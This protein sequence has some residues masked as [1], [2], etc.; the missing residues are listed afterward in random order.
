MPSFVPD[1]SLK[2]TFT[3]IV[4]DKSEYENED[5]SGSAFVD[6][7]AKKCV[8]KSCKFKFCT[9][10]RSYFRGALFEDCDFQG[11]R[12][13]DSNF[14]DAIFKG[15]C[16]FYYATFVG[17]LIESEQML[18]KLPPYPNLKLEFA[19]SLRANFAGLGMH[20]DAQS[21]FDVELASEYE[22][23]SK[24]VG[25]GETYYT[26]RYPTVRERF[27]YWVKLGL[28]RLEAFV[29]GHGASP[30]LLARATLFGLAVLSLVFMFLAP[31]YGGREFSSDP[32]GA[33]GDSVY[34]TLLTFFSADDQGF[35]PVSAV[36]KG[37]TV[38]TLLYG[39]LTLG[40]F[41]TAMYR[42]LARI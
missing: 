33:V 15:N 35:R 42:R 11:A 22:H 36:T 39:Y 7:G 12:F 4:P 18:T 28:H 13:R 6:V 24:I 25:S 8:F 3:G 31:G 5:F 30:L 37:F 20:V 14:R 27:P 9:F 40:L 21:F 2:H 38:L 23:F 26:T 29:W 10:E 16:V 34:Y 1:S 19:R 32:F 17:T 41:V